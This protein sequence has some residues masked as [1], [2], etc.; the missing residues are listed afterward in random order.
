MHRTLISFTVEE[1]KILDTEAARTGKSI[2]SLVRD[3]VDAVYG[4]D[5]STHDNLDL[6]R[7]SF[8]TWT[9]R[10]DDGF[11]VVERMRANTRRS[12]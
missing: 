1:R 3:A 12:R 6:M 2:S 10:H 8:G 9:E 11:E 5:R 7:Q 4:T